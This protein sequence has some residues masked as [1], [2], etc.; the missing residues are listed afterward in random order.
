MLTN[1]EK[2]NS[3]REEEIPLLPTNSVENR[4]WENKSSETPTV[5]GDLKQ[6]SSGS[7]DHVG[8]IGAYLRKGEISTQDLPIDYL[9]QLP[10][11]PED[12][13][14]EDPTILKK[15]ERAKNTCRNW[16]WL[17]NDE[18]CPFICA[19]TCCPIMLPLLCYGYV[20]DKCHEYK[21]HKREQI[22]EEAFESLRYKG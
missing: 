4:P 12:L 5:K 17:A 7:K 2:K 18:D 21:V 16:L 13:D 15:P 6:L 3:Q 1:L 11:K 22:F 8:I 9:Y 10:G 19:I 20:A 14:L